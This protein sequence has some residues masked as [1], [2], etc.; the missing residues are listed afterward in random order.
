MDLADDGIDGGEMPNPLDLAGEV[1]LDGAQ[2]VVTQFFELPDIFLRD[3]VVVH[4][5]IHGG[6]KEHLAFRRQHRAGQDVVGNPDGEFRQDVGGCG[7]DQN[8]VRRLGERRMKGCLLRGSEHIDVHGVPRK[9][10]KGQRLDKMGRLFR[11]HAGDVVAFFH[12]A[13]DEIR[14]DVAGDTPRETQ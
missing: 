3:G 6:A 14:R 11:H 13:I 12:Q 8:K 10:L 5:L 9:D 7:S 1:S 4:V 2:E